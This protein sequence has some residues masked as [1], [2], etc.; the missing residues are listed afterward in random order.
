MQ[1]N[2]NY[3]MCFLLLL[4]S[5][6]WG[7]EAHGPELSDKAPGLQTQAVPARPAPL[8]ELGGPFLG[9][10][11]IQKGIHLPTGAVWQP[12]FLMF[13]NLRTAAQ[14]FYNGSDYVS[15]WANRL[16]LYGNLYLTPTERFLVGIRLLDKEGQFSGYTWHAPPSVRPE[17]KSGFDEYHDFTLT[18]AFFEGDLGELFPFL[19]KY[20]ARGLDIG[21]AIGRQ[22]LKFQDGLLIDDTVD[23]IGVSKI[24]LKPPGMS[25]LRSSFVWGAADINRTNLTKADSNATLYGLFNELDFRAT[26]L[27]IDTIYVQSDA[28]HG[29]GMYAG[30]GAI[31]RIG[32]TNTTLRL[33]SSSSI[34][35]E[36]TNNSDGLLLFG[37]F[38]WNPNNSKNNLYLTGFRGFDRFRSASRD[39]LAG[40]PLARAGIL[41]E[42][43]GLGR[44][45]AALDNTA[46]NAFG[47]ALGYQMFFNDTRQQLTLEMGGRYATNETDQRAI[48]AGTR[49][50]TAIG[51][52]GVVRIDGFALYNATRDAA[53]FRPDNQF[54]LG[55]RV[56][57]SLQF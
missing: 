38:S 27:E 15:E 8:L 34:K 33:L 44:F 35:E 20:D 57:F 54:R 48:G 47:G 23:A 13:G 19:D 42:S 5:P 3:F 24:N 45:P 28:T 21:L 2:L 10:G 11:P 39:P 53:V 41:F 30:I 37:E 4:A 31:Q 14:S 9:T 40:G 1:K 32:P 52:R 18:T 22:P 29:K 56:E 7:A 43:V 51:R 16:D 49:F 25:N 36:T 6:V 46:D 50:E 12:S 55:G 26:T 17:G